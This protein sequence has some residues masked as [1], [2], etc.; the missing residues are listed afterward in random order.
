[1]R[2]ASVI[3]IS[4][5]DVPGMPVSVLF[6]GGCNFNCP[7]CQNSELIPLRSGNEVPVDE[8]AER[9]QGGLSEGYCITGGEPT[10]HGDLPM[11]LQRLRRECEKHLNLNTQGSV[12]QILASCIP[13][14]DSIWFDIKTA[15][16]KYPEVIRTQ[17]NPWDQ[18]EFSLRKVLDSDV[19]IW[20][21]TT[22]ASKLMNSQDLVRVME[23]LS[24]MGF[25]GEYVVQNYVESAGVSDEGRLCCVKPELS[26]VQ[27]ITECAP[28]GIQVRF[29]WR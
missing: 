9:V 13:F 4:L 23:V 12:P 20:P 19:Q 26:E 3:D 29:D 24:E 15:P 14:L 22:F 10:I 18:V 21:R 27:T 11:L 17:R 2:L 16:E 7:Y 25:R 6:T 5:V 28:A 1:M 8:I